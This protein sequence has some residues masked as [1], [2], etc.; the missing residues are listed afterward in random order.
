MPFCYVIIQREYVQYKTFV[1][2]DPGSLQVVETREDTRV[3]TVRK[4]ENYYTN[5][6][7]GTVINQYA[8]RKG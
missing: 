6:T 4:Q 2:R 5:K 8:Y 3:E 1:A 7:Y